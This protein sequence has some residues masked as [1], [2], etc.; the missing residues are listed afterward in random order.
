MFKRHF[1]FLFTKVFSLG[2]KFWFKN[3]ILFSSIVLW[4]FLHCVLCYTILTEKSAAILSFFFSVGICICLYFLERVFLIMGLNSLSMMCLGFVYLFLSFFA[5]FAFLFSV[6]FY[7]LPYFINFGEFFMNS[8]N[9]SYSE[10]AVFY[11]SFPLLQGAVYLRLCPQGTQP[12]CSPQYLRLRSI[13]DVGKEDVGTFTPSS[14]QLLLPG[15][16]LRTL[17]QP[18]IFHEHLAEICG[19]KSSSL[20]NLQGL[21]TAMLVHT[22]PLSIYWRI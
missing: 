10:T 13:R 18:H 1:S 6:Y 22:Q 3:P 4:M 21:S 15:V 20:C 2:N 11:F 9:I 5:W 12:F 8:W 19:L 16:F 14:Q 7:S 17:T